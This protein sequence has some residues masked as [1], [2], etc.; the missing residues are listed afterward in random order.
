MFTPHVPTLSPSPRCLAPGLPAGWWPGDCW[1]HRWCLDRGAG[2]TPCSLWACGAGAA[3]GSAQEGE[4]HP[5]PPH[6]HTSSRSPCR[7][8]R[9]GWLTGTEPGPPMGWGVPKPLPMLPSESVGPSP[10]PSGDLLRMAGVAMRM[11]VQRPGLSVSA[12]H[13]ACFPS[14][15][16]G[17]GGV[18]TGQRAG[19]GWVL[20]SQLVSLTGGLEKAGRRRQLQALHPAAPVWEPVQGAFVGLSSVDMD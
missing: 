18:C 14:W 17:S 2:R 20:R 5:D 11:D 12:L 1:P 13:A 9:E 10:Q 7:S 6:Q 16:R 19:S 4:P 8:Q 15:P 3:S